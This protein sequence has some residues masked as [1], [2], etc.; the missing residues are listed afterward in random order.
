M[1]SSRFL[2]V[3]GALLMGLCLMVAP[4]RQAA[5]QDEMVILTGD[6][7]QQLGH[8]QKV[9]Y[10][11]GVM[12]VVEMERNLKNGEFAEGER[13]FI[14]YMVNAM[15]GRTINDVVVKTNEYY[16]LHPDQLNRPVIDAIFQ[17]IV[18]PTL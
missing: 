15:Q 4:G 13:S 3:C 16:R 17:T 9:A 5:A 7:W 2:L 11:L 10:V 14:P 12:H 6:H 8:G 1:I 18:L